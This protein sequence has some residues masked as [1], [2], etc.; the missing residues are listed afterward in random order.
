MVGE[1]TY[2]PFKYRWSEWGRSMM[3]SDILQ[4]KERV[5]K[6]SR[7]VQVDVKIGDFDGV[8]LRESL[9]DLERQFTCS[10]RTEPPG[11]CWR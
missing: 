10:S 11:Q 7:V 8:K 9:V 1:G 3:K 2:I 4:T 5:E 6:E